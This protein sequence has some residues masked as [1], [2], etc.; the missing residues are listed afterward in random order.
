MFN[1]KNL[2]LNIK[3]TDAQPEETE[4]PKVALFQSLSGSSL[5][6]IEME[7]AF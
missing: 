4:P 1:E 5:I 3:E 2:K 7:D 6:D